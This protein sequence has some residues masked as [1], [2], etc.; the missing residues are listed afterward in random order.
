LLDTV[1]INI[2]AGLTVHKCTSVWHFVNEMDFSRTE[3]QGQGQGQGLGLGQ[4]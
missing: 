4:G 1:P 3:S 2:K